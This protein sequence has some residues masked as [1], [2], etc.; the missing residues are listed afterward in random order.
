MTVKFP[1]AVF[2]VS[3]ACPNA[4]PVVTPV[5]HRPVK[6]EAKDDAAVVAARA[7]IKTVALFC[8]VVFLSELL[9]AD[10]KFR[11]SMVVDLLFR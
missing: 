10:S 5:S 1:S 9:N 11:V 4:Q 7:R 8:L 2:D 3:G 6:V